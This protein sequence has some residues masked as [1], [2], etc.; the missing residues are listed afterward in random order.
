MN[1]IDLL[2]KQVLFVDLDS[3][4]IHTA[5]GM[6]YPTD[7]CDFVINKEFIDKIALMLP[8]LEFLFVI[9]NQLSIG[10]LILEGEFIA[11]LSAI[12]EF[13]R[14]Y[15]EEKRFENIIV[16]HRYCTPSR[17]SHFLMPDTGMLQDLCSLYDLTDKGCMLMVGGLS[18]K[19]KDISDIDRQCADNFSIDYI[20][21]CDFMNLK[22]SY[23]Q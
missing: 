17:C 3:A 7:C 4:L 5:S 1:N 15:L 8:S 11:K 16:N 23:R 20:D 18:G 14:V 2:K 19:P 9:S 6:L 21:I 10:R 12:C 13:A 22:E